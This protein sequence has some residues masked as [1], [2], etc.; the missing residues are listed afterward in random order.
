[1]TISKMTFGAVALLG[2][3]ACGGGNGDQGNPP[4]HSSGFA[5]ASSDVG[6]VGV[7]NAGNVYLS[8]WAVSSGAS[9]VT[10]SPSFD[11]QVSSLSIT[12]DGVTYPL[13]SGGSG[14]TFG[15]GNITGFIQPFTTGDQ[16]V[17]ILYI[18]MSDTAGVF[19]DGYFPIGFN[20]DPS[21]IS[22]A[23]GIISLSGTSAGFFNDDN[24]TF[25]FLTGSVN[26]NVNFDSGT[27]NGNGTIS[28]SGGQIATYTI[29]TT[30]I[31]G[32]A[33]NT[34]ATATFSTPGV[35]ASSA[36]V[37]GQFYGST[38]TAVGGTY[39]IEGTSPTG[40]FAATGGFAAN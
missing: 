3:A 39:A 8:Q 4:S 15:G 17:D 13:T 22:S 9:V 11:F 35:T 21:V 18:S 31:V 10:K 24:G 34:S 1:M 19:V 2:L 27:L 14:L 38:G 40:D 37:D 12:I 20:T 28:D 5:T 29:P 6:Q 16:A 25:D 26:F 7:Y 33:F 30:S 23:S 36:T 32:N